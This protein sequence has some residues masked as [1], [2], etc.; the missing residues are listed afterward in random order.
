MGGMVPAL[1]CGYPQKEIRDAAYAYQQAVE[2]KEK[3]IVGVNE[4]VTEEDRSIKLLVIDDSVARHQVKKLEE[5]RQKRDNAVVRGN[6][7]C[8]VAPLLQS[9]LMPFI[10][11]CV[12]AYALW[13]KCARYCATPLAL[14]KSRR[15]E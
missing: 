3:I 2:R 10:L 15:F 6:S 11:E 7:S 12:R 14:M 13:A 5:L 8:C 1:E 4:Y 9:N